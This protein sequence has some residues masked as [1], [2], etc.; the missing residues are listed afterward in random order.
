MGHLFVADLAQLYQSNAAFD[1]SQHNSTQKDTVVRLVNILHSLKWLTWFSCLSLHVS[2]SLNIYTYSTKKFL[3]K[4]LATFNSL[5]IYVL[6]ITSCYFYQH[7]VNTNS[8]TN[9]I[10]FCKL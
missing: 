8:F 1:S 2:K 4:V 5:T 3:L 10:N 9:T 7:T 6:R